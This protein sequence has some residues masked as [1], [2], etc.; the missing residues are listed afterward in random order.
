MQPSTALETALKAVSTALEAAPKKCLYRQDV[1]AAPWGF[2]QLATDVSSKRP[3][4]KGLEQEAAK[5]LAMVQCVHPAL[6]PATLPRAL[7][8]LLLHQGCS[9]SC[10]FLRGPAHAALARV[11]GV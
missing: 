8:A 6:N 4:A 1:Q 5:G 10:Y 3:E 2:H 7:P 9:I 11:H